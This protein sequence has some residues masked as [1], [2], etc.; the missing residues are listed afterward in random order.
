[1]ILNA[2]NIKDAF[3]AAPQAL[4]DALNSDEVYDAFHEIREKHNLHIDHA[5]NLATAINAVVL[6]VVP[7]TDM[8]RLLDEGMPGVS[9]ETKQGVLTDLN[10]MIFIPLREKALSVAARP[11]HPPAVPTVPDAPIP[12]PPVSVIAQ[13]LSHPQV[14]E[15]LAT[16]P[17]PAPAPPAPA[18]YRSQD[19]YREIPE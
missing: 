4:K 19:P 14:S 1:M 11:S 17:P 9:P 12:K 16:P 6:G 10:D 7:F 8:G 18:Q 15:T 3:S 13:K 2:Q 5:G